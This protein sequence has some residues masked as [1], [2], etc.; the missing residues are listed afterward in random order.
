MKVKFEMFGASVFRLRYTNWSWCNKTKYGTCLKH[1]RSWIESYNVFDYDVTPYAVHTYIHKDKRT[2][3]YWLVEQKIL[4]GSGKIGSFA[5][6]EHTPVYQVEFV[7][8]HPQNSDY[9][10]VKRSDW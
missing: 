5:T 3:T 9:C 10:I 6:V 8:L 1:G 7:K 2:K 4:S